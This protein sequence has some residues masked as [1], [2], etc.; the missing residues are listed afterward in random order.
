MNSSDSL[1]DNIINASDLSNIAI[2]KGVKMLCFPE[3]ALLMPSSKHN[4]LSQSFSENQNPGLKFFTNLAK[5]NNIWVLVGSLSIKVSKD[6][7]VNRSYLID[8]Y[9]KIIGTYDKIHLFDVTLSNGVSY[10]ESDRYSPG[11]H[12]SVI[13]TPLANFGLTICYDVRF[14]SLYRKIALRG[15]NIIFVPSAFT[16]FTGQ[17]HWSVLLRA[18]AIET[19]SYIIAPAQTGK[20]HGGRETYGHSMVVAPDGKVMIDGGEDP[21]IITC[22][23]DI[24]KVHEA[25]ETIPSLFLNPVYSIEVK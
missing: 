8:N 1:E 24:D 16:K 13:K 6:K 25:R 3:N 23:I 15:A 17:M 22:E 9:G 14:P 5:K 7:V 10:R 11:Q 12:G 19:G 4:L 2:S 21:G 18:R 20:H